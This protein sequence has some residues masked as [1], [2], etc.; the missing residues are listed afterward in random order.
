MRGG[1][2]ELRWR[3]A[4]CVRSSLPNLTLGFSSH[5]PTLSGAGIREHHAGSEGLY[6]NRA[7]DNFAYFSCGSWTCSSPSKDG[8]LISASLSHRGGWR[9]RF[10]VTVSGE[11]LVDSTVHAQRRDTADPPTTLGLVDVKTFYNDEGAGFELEQSLTG[12]C[13]KP[14]IL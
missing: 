1:H 4:G 13:A 14:W 12:R 7:D 11:S 5:T 6:L 9:R 8:V 10:D 3:C 2:E